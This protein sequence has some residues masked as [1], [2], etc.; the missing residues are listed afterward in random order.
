MHFTDCF[1]SLIEIN[2]TVETHIYKHVAELIPDTLDA[3]EVG[4]LT[5]NQRSIVPSV[6]W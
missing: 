3:V 1:D 2:Q 5:R 4:N 6:F